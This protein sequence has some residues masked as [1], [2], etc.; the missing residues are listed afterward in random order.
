MPL[1]LNLPNPVA[2]LGKSCTED[3]FGSLQDGAQPH[4]ESLSTRQEDTI[5]LSASDTAQDAQDAPVASTKREG[6]WKDAQQHTGNGA[7][8]RQNAVKQKAQPLKVTFCKLLEMLGNKET[9]LRVSLANAEAARAILT[10]LCSQEFW[11]MAS[12]KCKWYPVLNV[13]V[14]L[15][16]R[17]VAQAVSHNER[18]RI[19]IF[20]F[21]FLLAAEYLSSTS[22]KLMSSDKPLTVLGWGGTSPPPSPNPTQPHP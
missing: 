7:P 10:P 15:T 18:Q 4:H 6:S 12:L 21:L 8:V 19:V 2:H 5:D 16:K 3:N 13:S 14:D 1:S 17:I 9:C 22:I 11:Y 20:I